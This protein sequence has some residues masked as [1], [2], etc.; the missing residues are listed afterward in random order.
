MNPKTKP[1]ETLINPKKACSQPAERQG[2]QA[3]AALTWMG[4]ITMSKLELLAEVVLHGCLLIHMWRMSD[5]SAA[6]S[7]LDG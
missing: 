3:N 5:V 7:Y 2:Q 1:P 6:L 4:E